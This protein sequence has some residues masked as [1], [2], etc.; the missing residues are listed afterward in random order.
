MKKP[1][2]LQYTIDEGQLPGETARLLGNSLSRLSSIVATAPDAHDIMSI[3]TIDDIGGLRQELSAIDIML[4]DVSSIIDQ[5]IQYQYQM[6]MEHELGEVEE[7]G[8]Y[9]YDIPDT[10]DVDLSNVGME[11]L[12]SMLS[13]TQEY[14]HAGPE[15]LE[16]INAIIPNLKTKKVKLPAMDAEARQKQIEIVDNQLT[17]AQEF[18]EA[19]QNMSQEEAA[20]LLSKLNN[21]DFTDV[22]TIGDQLKTIGINM[23]IE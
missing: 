21:I 12:Q 14:S 17:K 22:D 4:G 7:I 20:T 11:D 5:Y 9:E 19:T 2:T 18:K 6:R 16:D 15:Q 3:K 10:T 13:K 23:G 1:I 8:D